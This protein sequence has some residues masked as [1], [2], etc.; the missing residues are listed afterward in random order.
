MKGI[1]KF[2]GDPFWS[3]FLKAKKTEPVFFSKALFGLVLTL[4]A[5]A[6]LGLLEKFGLWL[7]SGDFVKELEPIK[8]QPI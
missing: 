2:F 3:G 6:I 4:G 5:V 1:P 7:C 8:S